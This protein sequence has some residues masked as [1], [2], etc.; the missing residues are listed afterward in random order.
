MSEETHEG[1][2]KHLAEGG[3]D[4]TKAL[5]EDLFGVI[6]NSE[7]DFFTQLLSIVCILSVVIEI[8]YLLL[9]AVIRSKLDTL[10]FNEKRKGRFTYTCIPA[11]ISLLILFGNLLQKYSVA[12]HSLEAKLSESRIEKEFRHRQ[13]FLVDMHTFQLIIISSVWLSINGLMKINRDRVKG[14]QTIAD[15]A[16]NGAKEVEILKEDKPAPE[17]VE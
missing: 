10:D 16:K 17:K 5:A 8:V 11:T 15:H 14:Q 4:L 9:P 1:F 12:E 2:A 13:L 7:L 6:F 3:F